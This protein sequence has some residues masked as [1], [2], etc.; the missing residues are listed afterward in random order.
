VPF[1]WYL[2][3][4][5]ITGDPFFPT[6]RTLPLGTS[7]SPLTS[8]LGVISTFSPAGIRDRLVGMLNLSPFSIIGLVFGAVYLFR[9]KRSVLKKRPIV[10]F[11]IIIT[12]TQLIIN[13]S[14]HRFLLPFY[15]VFAIALAI[16][17][18]KFISFNKL[19][20]LTFYSLFLVFFAYY[21]INTLLILPYGLGFADGNKYLS[22]ILSRDNSTYYDY[23]HQF[24]KFI[25]NNE[26]VA[27]YGLWAFYYA[28]FNNLYSEDVF[29]KKPKSL[30]SLKQAGV[31]KLIILGL[32]MNWFCKVEKI[33]DC[34]PNNY[35]L[36][37]SYKF[38]TET[39][40][41]ALYLLK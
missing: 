8:L 13:Y 23:N 7:D 15:S 37:T 24:S 20:K 25:P 22:R 5:I 16:G 26:L 10:L 9:I 3:A 36:L 32:D 38:P 31:T 34:T 18:D 4:F 30:A 19:F 2:R 41:Q 21:F 12:I 28:N 39:K 40:E 11:I 27:T 14:Y 17:I 1:L 33:T 35:K 29:M 6:Y